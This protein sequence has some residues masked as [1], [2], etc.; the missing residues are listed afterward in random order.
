MAVPHLLRELL[1]LAVGQQGTQRLLR[2][3]RIALKGQIY[4]ILQSGLIQL[5]E[6]CQ[7]C[8]GLGLPEHPGQIGLGKITVFLKH[9]IASC[10]LG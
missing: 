9:S 1:H 10:S 2:P 3:G 5:L 8:L 7:K 6:P 4:R